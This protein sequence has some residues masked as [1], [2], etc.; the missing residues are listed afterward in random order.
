MSLS[1]SQLGFRFEGKSLGKEGPARVSATV[2]R[3]GDDKLT[4]LG[5]LLWADGTSERLTG[6]PN[7]QAF[8]RRT[9]AGG[10]EEERRAAKGKDEEAEGKRRR[11]TTTEMKERREE[12]KA[13]AK[14]LYAVNYPLGDFG[15]AEPPKQPK[16]IAFKNATLWTC[17]PAGIIEGGTLRRSRGKNRGGR[18]RTWRFPRARKSS[19]PPGG[20][21]RR[22]SSTAIRTWR[23]TAAS[24]RGRRRSRPKCASATSSTPTTS[25]SIASLP[26]ASLRRTFCTA[27]PT[28]SAGRTR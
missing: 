1:E 18:V 3:G 14:A 28:R 7:R 21:L 16:V 4:L 11:Q 6:T 9:A 15:R 19:M 22:A 27:R 23:P 25:P 8:G 17:G 12:E 5:T 2:I 20:T 13:E 24:T 26:A 10:A